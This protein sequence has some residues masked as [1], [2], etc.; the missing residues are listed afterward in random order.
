MKRLIVILFIVF[1]IKGFSQVRVPDT[2]TFS[3]EDVWGAVKDHTP[4]TND[5]LQACFDNARTDYFDVN[6]SYPINS[7]LKFRNYGPQPWNVGSFTYDTTYIFSLPD[8]TIQDIWFN[9]TGTKLFLLV[10][11]VY[12]GGKVYEYTLNTAFDISTY[13]QSNIL[14]ISPTENIPQGLFITSDGSNMFIV[15]SSSDEVKQYFLSP[16]FSTSNA[17]YIN[18]FDVSN[19]L[20]FPTDIYFKYDGSIMYI[21]G[22]N[23]II[24]YLLGESW[25]ISLAEFAG[26]EYNIG[27]G[28]IDDIFFNPDGEKMFLTSYFNYPKI[29]QYDLYLPWMPGTRQNDEDI[30][31][32]STGNTGIFISLDGTKLFVVGH[33]SGYPGNFINKYSIE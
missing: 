23:E 17:S 19:E 24:A 5:D 4:L 30:Q 27:I 32:N 20:F 21:T 29:F 28:S 13:S 6:Y 3:L 16:A 11:N 25:N 1:F 15:G 14:T 22:T 8:E 9:P 33:T 18:S 31:L 12:S 7:M 10:S 2:E 26:A